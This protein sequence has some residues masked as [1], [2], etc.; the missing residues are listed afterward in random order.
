MLNLALLGVLLVPLLLVVMGRWRSALLFSVVVGFL[1]DPLRKLAEGEPV[2]FVVLVLVAALIAGLSPL[3]NDGVALK[4]LFYRSNQISMVV[5]LFG[6]LVFVQVLHSLALFGR[7]MLPA[8]GLIFY[9]AP[10]FS[11]W[12]GSRYAATPL[13][14]EKLLRVYVGSA[15]LMALTLVLSF[16]G[17]ESELFREVGGGVILYSFGGVFET[18]VGLFRASEIAAWHLVTAACFIIILGLVSGKQRWIVLA[19]LIGLALVALTTLTG[20]RKVLALFAAFAVVYATLIWT[21]RG[22]SARSNLLVGVLGTGLVLLSFLLFMAEQRLGEG[23]VNYVARASTVWG[24]LDD[25]MLQLGIGSI[26]WAWNRGGLTGLGVGAAAQGAQHFGGVTSGGAGEGGL[27]KLMVELGPLGLGLFV[28]LL[29][30]LL[31]H[32]LKILAVVRTQS[33]RLQLLLL[34]VFAW[35]GSNVPMFM[36]ASQVY[37]DPFVLL[38]L[39]LGAGML[40]AVPE[41]LQRFSR[42]KPVAAPGRRYAAIPPL[43][44]VRRGPRIGPSVIPPGRRARSIAVSESDHLPGTPVDTHRPKP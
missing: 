21:T 3:F 42:H 29:V 40:L 4:R 43:R 20:R 5:V 44:S 1:Q 27:G 26:G 25:R 10:F 30:L 34:G 14:M 8:I 36:V 38:M 12:L 24:D 16:L 11:L 7:P 35:L 41:M 13:D 31:F 17:V 23:L 15:L 2:V 9:V 39:G 18:H 32:F 37:G 6:L 28:L 19:L 33:M 22:A